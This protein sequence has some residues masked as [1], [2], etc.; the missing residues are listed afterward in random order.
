MAKRALRAIEV[1]RPYLEAVGA[2]F[3]LSKGRIR[4]I[5]RGFSPKAFPFLW[6]TQLSKLAAGNIA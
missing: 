2:D 4:V 6:L 5:L 3:R 1:N